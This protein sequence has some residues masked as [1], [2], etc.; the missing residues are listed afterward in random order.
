MYRTR[1]ETDLLNPAMRRVNRAQQAATR[2]LDEYGPQ[3]LPIDVYA[4]ARCHAHVEERTLASTDLSGALIPIEGNRWVILVNKAHAPVR[5]RFTV[6][7]ELGH[8][9]LHHYRVP[10]AD[11]GFKFRDALSSTGTAFEEIEANQFAAEL[12]MPRRLLLEAIRDRLVGHAA[13]D[14]EDKEFDEL[15]D[16]LAK[17][18]KVSRQAMAIRLGTLLK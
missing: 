11:R 3:S 6:A 9:L 17:R 14:E 1:V 10:H 13:S 2:L 18:F 16:E 5:R 12:L 7:H 4:L 15:V 8:L